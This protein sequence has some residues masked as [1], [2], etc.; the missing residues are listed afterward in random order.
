MYK[1]RSVL[2]HHLIINLV[3]MFSLLTYQNIYSQTHKVGGLITIG[4]VNS[5]GVG[6]IS[7]AI[8]GTSITT[9]SDNDGEY[10]IHVPDN[11]TILVYSYPGM[12]T[13]EIIVR[14]RSRIDVDLLKFPSKKEV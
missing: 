2:K 5:P 1:L 9:I 10:R 8:K 11:K 6:G 14:T 4:E 13:Q 12:I 3:L 7:I